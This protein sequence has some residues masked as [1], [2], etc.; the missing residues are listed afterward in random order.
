MKTDLSSSFH[1]DLFDKCLMWSR[2]CPLKIA[3]HFKGW[4]SYSFPIQASISRQ[5]VNAWPSYLQLSQIELDTVWISSAGTSGGCY[6][7]MKSEIN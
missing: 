1:K 4:G 7:S 5:H 2:F 6:Q 3:F